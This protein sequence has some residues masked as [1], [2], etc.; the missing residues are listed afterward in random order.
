LVLA[1]SQE[2]DLIFVDQY[3][4][5]TEKQLLG[6]ETVAALRSKGCSARICGLSA[7]DVETAFLNA[8]SD[9]FILKPIAVSK[10]G[11]ARKLRHVVFG[12]RQWKPK[13][14]AFETAVSSLI[15]K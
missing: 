7:N 12:E 4:A 13:A 9:F 10:E 6:T 1:A 15:T 3:M 2:F 8:G 11:L 5:S 14:I